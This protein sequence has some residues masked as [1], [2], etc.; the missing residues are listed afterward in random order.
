[1][2]ND[3]TKQPSPRPPRSADIRPR[4]L[5][6]AHSLKLV[7][8]TDDQP[9]PP[10]AIL[11]HRWIQEEEISFQEMKSLELLDQDRDVVERVK[12]KGGYKKIKYACRQA[13][14]ESIPF[15]WIDTCC[16]NQKDDKDVAR[17][18]RSMFLYYRN[19]VVC[20][21]FLVDVDVRYRKQHR[22][23]DSE[24]FRR[25]WTLQ[26]LIAPLRVVFFDNRWKRIGC[27]CDDALG[28]K[29]SSIT[30]IPRRVLVGKRPLRKTGVLER[31]SWAMGR[32]T[33]RPQDRAY[34]LSGL[35]GVSMDPDYEESALVA[36]ARL[37]KA[38][39]ER[40]RGQED[41]LRALGTP[42]HLYSVLIGKHYAAVASNGVNGA[43]KRKKR[44]VEVRLYRACGFFIIVP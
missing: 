39:V 14:R 6:D 13:L 20:Y 22:M 4:R 34:C 1:M 33:T 44:K 3:D 17:N 35:L 12:S 38:V 25:G 43:K 2:S 31:M 9:T 23:R 32:F 37:R 27:K 16:I 7:D 36:F 15:I 28:S 8:L 26:E 18:I 11:S 40:H 30:G 5:I 21:V 24:W 19:A 41:K 10:Y 29:I 42:Q